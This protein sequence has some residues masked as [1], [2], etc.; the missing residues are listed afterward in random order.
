MN[1]VR[2]VLLALAIAV[3]VPSDHLLIGQPKDPFPGT[4][5]LARGKSDFTPPTPFYKRTVIIE[6]I[7]G[8]YKI[9]TRT[10]SDRQQTIES[11]YSARFDGK[12]VPIDN[13]VLDTMSLRRIDANTIEGAAKLKGQ[14]VEN[15]TMKVSS[16]GKALTVTTKGS[17][18]G[19]DYSSTQVFNR[20]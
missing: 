2:L 18:N 20:Q 19:D 8:G 6:P 7:D 16:D 11:T 5:L 13:S 3:V 15:A 12:D 14:V 1:P 4:W 10:V 9:T 17:I